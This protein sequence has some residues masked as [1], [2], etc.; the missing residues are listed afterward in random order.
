MF[1]TKKDA[2]NWIKSFAGGLQFEARKR[3]NYW[4]IYD[5]EGFVL[6]DERIDSIEDSNS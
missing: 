4:R 1:S 6:S 5:A 3:G 2:I